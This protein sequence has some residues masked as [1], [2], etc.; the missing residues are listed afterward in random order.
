VQN[1]SKQKTDVD[2]SYSATSVLVLHVATNFEKQ[3]TGQLFSERI[4]ANILQ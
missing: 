4:F 3:M 2:S 1:D